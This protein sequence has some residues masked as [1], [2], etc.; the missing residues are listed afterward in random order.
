[1]S[2]SKSYIIFFVVYHTKCIDPWLTKNRR[3]CPICKRKVF[4][5]DEPHT[6][7]TDS[8]SD[9]DDTSPLINSSNN[10]VTQGGT[11]VEQHENP[12]QRAV[13]SISQ[14]SGA[15]TNHNLVTASDHHSING[16]CSEYES[17]QS[18]SDTDTDDGNCNNG[19]VCDNLEVHVHVNADN[20]DLNV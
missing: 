4:A 2:F 5:H 9:A 17:V 18:D 3:V 7:D 16:E 15:T 20:N 13:R 1:M 10:R 6:N 12:I 14:Q 8:D 11:F 19:M